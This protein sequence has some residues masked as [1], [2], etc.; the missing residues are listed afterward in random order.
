MEKVIKNDLI[1]EAKNLCTKIHK[2]A[3]YFLDDKELPYYH[4]CYI[5]ADIVKN[6]A[7]NNINKS[8]AEILAYLHDSIEDTKI[9]YDFLQN[10]FNK[11]IADGVFALT[12]NSNLPHDQQIIDSLNRI[13]K[14]PKEVA[15][16]KMADR[17]CNLKK[18]PDFWS[19]QKCENYLVESKLILNE[20]GFA[21]KNLQNLLT[22]SITNYKQKII[23]RKNLYK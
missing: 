1:D 12:K 11:E 3:K 13:K 8:F 19:D 4:H 7:E 17:I 21:S 10:N 5:V 18:I 6:Y 23:N 16:V 14:Q 15:I 22:D 9:T 20:L 2:D